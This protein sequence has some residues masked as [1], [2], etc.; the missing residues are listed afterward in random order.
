MSTQA[1]HSLKRLFILDRFPAKPAPK[2]QLFPLGA[3][4]RP[5]KVWYFSGQV[6]PTGGG[7]PRSGSTAPTFSTCRGIIETALCAVDRSRSE[8][9]G[10]VRNPL[11]KSRHLISS[12]T[13]T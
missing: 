11:V 13:D 1:F 10:E 6:A 12:S 8:L 4:E 3:G 7:Q 2:A 9:G 5:T